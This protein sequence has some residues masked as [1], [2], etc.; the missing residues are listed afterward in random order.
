MIKGRDT[1]N[2]KRQQLELKK[3]CGCCRWYCR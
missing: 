2:S 3:N 1:K